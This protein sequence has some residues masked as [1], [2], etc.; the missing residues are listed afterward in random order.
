MPN[1]GDTDVMVGDIFMSSGG[2]YKSLGSTSSF[3]VLRL[4]EPLTNTPAGA[5]I[6]KQIARILQDEDTVHFEVEQAYASLIFTLLDAYTQRLRSDSTLPIQAKLLQ[7]R[8]QPPLSISELQVLREFTDMCAEQIARVKQLDEPLFAAALAPLLRSFGFNETDDEERHHKA[9]VESDTVGAQDEQHRA[10]EE[11]IPEDTES[12]TA[13]A[14]V[15][16]RVVSAYR[17]H[18]DEKRKDIQKLQST[19]A[20]QIMETI[21]QN[22]EFG[23]LLEI[24]LGELRQSADAQ[25]MEKLKTLMVSEIE[26]LLKEHRVLAEK[27]D[28]THHYLQMVES[29]SRQLA[30]ELTRVR[31]LSLTDE[32]TG[33]PNRRAFLRRLEDEVGRVHRYGFPLALAVIDLDRFKDI[34]DK[35]GHA[36]GDEVLRCYSRNILSIFRHHDLVAR[37]GG[38][39]F[40]VLLPNTDKEG[41]LRAL[42]KVQKRA[43]ESHVQLDDTPLAVPPFSAGLAV[44]HPGETPSS[45]IKRADNA[46]Y[47]A[48]RMG[49]NRVELDQTYSTQA[50]EEGG[51]SPGNSVETP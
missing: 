49:R 18:L 14:A 15:E 16:Q 28:S 44:Y 13:V 34:N 36:A 4:L 48:K 38:E 45:L 6:H 47:R 35:Y 51:A 9:E 41:S 25:G 46:L 24:V 31:L 40:A 7:Q 27:L 1:S 42:G 21:T 5:L 3:K 39:E 8:L 37:Y 12:S 32:L 33:L 20:H 23:V 43:S 30:D 10:A 29:G 17:H 50:A 26:K 19:L 2:E 22:E 11:Q